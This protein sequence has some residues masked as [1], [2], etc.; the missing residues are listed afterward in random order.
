MLGYYT[1]TGEYFNFYKNE[2]NENKFCAGRERIIWAS[3]PL[4]WSPRTAFA[5]V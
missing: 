3:Y 1:N 5:P 2:K 4:L